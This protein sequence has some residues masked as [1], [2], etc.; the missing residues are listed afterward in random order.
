MPLLEEI[1][2]LVHKTY[3]RPRNTWAPEKRDGKSTLPARD[4]ILACALPS[5]QWEVGPSTVLTARHKV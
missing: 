2:A 1:P 4:D 5:P 3:S